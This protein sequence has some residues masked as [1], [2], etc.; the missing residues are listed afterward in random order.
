MLSLCGLALTHSLSIYPSVCLPVSLSVRG[1]ARL[2]KNPHR[3]PGYVLCSFAR[4]EERGSVTMTM[5][6]ETNLTANHVCVCVC[7]Y[8]FVSSCLIIRCLCRCASAFE[9]DSRYIEEEEEEGQEEG[10]EER[11]SEVMWS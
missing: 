3:F 6:L 9:M 4:A 10:R 7:V 8:I 5:A 1:V 2:H 11:M